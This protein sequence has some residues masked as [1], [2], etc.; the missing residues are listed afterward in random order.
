MP[1]AIGTYLQFLG[2][3]KGNRNSLYYLGNHLVSSDQQLEYFPKT[4][5]VDFLRQF[6]ALK[7]QDTGCKRV[8]EKWVWDWVL[9]GR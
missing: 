3:T 7:Q 8:N 6:M 4:A 1:L 5:T 2:E 9:N